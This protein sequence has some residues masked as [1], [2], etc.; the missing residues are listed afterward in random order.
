MTSP[1]LLPGLDGRNPL[2]FLAAL[3]TVAL[4]SRAYAEQTVRLSWCKDSGGWRPQLHFHHCETADG[5]LDKLSTAQLLSRVS[6]AFDL[7]DDLDLPLALF[8]QAAL[9]ALLGGSAGDRTYLDFLSAFGSEAVEAKSNGKATGTISDTAFRT[10]SGAGH[11]HFLKTMRTL[12]ADTTVEHVKNTLF[13]RWTYGDP[14]KNHT[15][16]W[17]PADDVRYALRWA[18]PSDDKDRADRGSMWGAN[19][20]AVEAL[21]LFPTVPRGSRLATTGI[22]EAPPTGTTFTW[23]IWEA[24]VGIDVVRSLL[25]LDE[26]RSSSPD[27]T[28]L[29]RRGVVAV[30][31]STRFTQGKFRN[32]GLAAAVV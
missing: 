27:R 11:Q 28:V 23:P 32:F 9:A 18:N 6:P 30:F 3:G 19:H 7:G 26:L 2:G 10:M 25:A 22:V 15:M 29:E 5:L 16:R 4:A 21:V 14:S 17:D 20:L 12:C 24:P 13:A 31:R 8:R 1:L